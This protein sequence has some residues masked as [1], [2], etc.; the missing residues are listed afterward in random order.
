MQFEVK[1]NVA[2]AEW[3]PW[4]NNEPFATLKQTA[5]SAL[6]K[7]ALAKKQKQKRELNKT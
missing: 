6:E 2:T 7:V 5:S 1:L 3:Q 4:A